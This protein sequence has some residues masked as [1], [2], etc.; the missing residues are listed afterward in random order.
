MCMTFALL[1]AHN[2]IVGCMRCTRKRVGMVINYIII[3]HIKDMSRGNTIIH[4]AL[5]SQP[6]NKRALQLAEKGCLPSIVVNTDRWSINLL[7]IAGR[8]GMSIPIGVNMDRWSINLLSA[9]LRT[10][11]PFQL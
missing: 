8:K 3:S 9:D 10:G 6:C 2:S 1:D 5:V 4:S 7:S 11:S